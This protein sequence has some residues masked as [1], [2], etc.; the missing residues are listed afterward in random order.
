MIC[1]AVMV[2]PPQSAEIDRFDEEVLAA[3]AAAA[4]MS[5]VRLDVEVLALE[6]ALGRLGAMA[7]WRS[8]LRAG[9][10]KSERKKKIGGERASE[11]FWTPPLA[12]YK[13]V[14][15]LESYGVDVR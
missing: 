10:K 13:R 6:A 4:A 1:S 14:K 7:Y 3:A 8:E 12:I 15:T 5:T 11:G 2:D 9:K